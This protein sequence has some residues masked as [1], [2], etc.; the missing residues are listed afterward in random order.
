MCDRDQFLEC[1]GARLR[2]RVAGSG[3]AVLL[4]H[5]WALDMDMWTPQFAA[6]AAQC[7]V[8]A[9]DRRGFGQSTGEPD[10]AQDV[11]DVLCLLAALGIERAAIVGMSQ[12]ARVALRCA[13][14]FPHAVTCMALDGPPQERATQEAGAVEELPMAKYRELMRRLGIEA[15]RE[16]WAR[17]PF[18]LL[19]TR[20]ERMHAL[21]R[22]IIG[23]YPGR[24]LQNA[25]AEHP[26][27]V[28]RPDSVRAPTLVINGE[29][30][31]K[32]RLAAGAWIAQWLPDA[33]R[34]IVPGAGHLPN[35]DNPVAYNKLLGGFVRLHAGAPMSER[36]N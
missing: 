22:K 17:N 16:E 26:I 2:F 31:S 30:D 18:M 13:L 3:P 21:L 19:R 9:F 4:I 23:R 20:D 24:D 29:H 6:L 34:S 32:H 1:D 11:E 8:V 15:V 5:G 14:R 27:L 7:C 35:L 33:R 28:D 36:E 12:G 25:A 10:V